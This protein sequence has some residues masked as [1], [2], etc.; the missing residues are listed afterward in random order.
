MKR[1]FGGF[2]GFHMSGSGGA[3]HTRAPDTTTTSRSTRQRL[4]PAPGASMRPRMW[5]TS[6][7][8]HSIGKLASRARF[9][10]PSAAATDTSASSGTKCLYPYE[11]M[12]S[13]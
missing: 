1:L 11:T 2:V 5:R 6:P 8:T 9:I 4:S 12:G 3:S 7:E 10:A 13:A